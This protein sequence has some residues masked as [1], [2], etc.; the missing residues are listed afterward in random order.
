MIS[1]C[2]ASIGHLKSLRS[3]IWKKFN[4][5]EMITN[6]CVPS[7]WERS[8]TIFPQLRKSE[9]KLW[10]LKA[11]VNR[12]N[13]RCTRVKAQSSTIQISHIHQTSDRL[14]N[15][16]SWSISI[17][18][19]SGRRR[20]MKRKKLGHAAWTQISYLRVALRLL[21]TKSAGLSPVP[22]QII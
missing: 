3:Y 20:N 8:N 18:R 15:R 21:R 19:V 4:K 11:C 5:K 12:E 13:E 10:P 2:Q 22:D 6:K 1:Y 9:W 7:S 16:R 14:W 17:T